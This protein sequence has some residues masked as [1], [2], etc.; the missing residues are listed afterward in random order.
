MGHNYIKN[1]GI[2]NIRKI[3]NTYFLDLK[4]DENQVV[5]ECK[6]YIKYYRQNLDIETHENG[7][8]AIFIY[9]ISKNILQNNILSGEMLTKLAVI[10]N[11][12]ISACTNYISPFSDVEFP[13]IIKGNFNYI[14]GGYSIQNNLECG[15][16][17]R[18]FDKN[19]VFDDNKVYIGKN[20]K[21]DNN[22]KIYSEIGNNVVI[23][24]DAVIREKIDDGEIVSVKNSIQVKSE[25]K[26]AKCPLVYGIVPK[27]RNL[28]VVYGEGFY[29]PKIKIVV[30]Y[31][32][33]DFSICYWDKNKIIIRLER[34]EM[35]KSSDKN[36][37][38]IFSNGSRISLIN[39][40]GVQKSFKNWKK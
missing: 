21:I 25:K 39:D 27:F 30:L 15:N 40:I 6:S 9:L 8:Y 5:N 1:F 38:I 34:V 32:R 33:V 14:G 12:T 31:G 23:E 35:D 7:L 28:M 36:T 24:S 19:T 18:F 11:H 2:R 16:N 17:N 3:K 13:I 22:V 37:L 4:F 10:K 20:V 26:M 29:N